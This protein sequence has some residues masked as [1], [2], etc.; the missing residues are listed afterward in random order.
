MT[1]KRFDAR[2]SIMCTGAERDMLE[3]LA[4][5][6]GSTASEVVRRFIR[7]RHAHLFGRPLPKTT[8][9]RRLKK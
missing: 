5:E 4:R 7:T 2:L 9:K 8:P 3:D 1:I 6:D